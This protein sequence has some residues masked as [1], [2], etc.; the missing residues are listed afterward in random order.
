MAIAAIDDNSSDGSE[1]SKFKA[2]W[3]RF[4]IL[5]AIKDSHNSWEEVKI[6]TL[7]GVWKKSISAIMDDFVEFKTSAEEVTANVVQTGREPE[8]EV[9]PEDVTE[10]SPSHGKTWTKEELLLMHEQREYSFLR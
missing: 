9:E 7:T 10:L 1:Q 8:S 5:G 3:K 2:F 4:T 6:W